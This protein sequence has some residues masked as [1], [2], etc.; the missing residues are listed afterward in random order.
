MVTKDIVMDKD[1]E[2]GEER[3]REVIS[4]SHA[5][6]EAYLLRDQEDKA[7][8][9]SPN[10]YQTIIELLSKST[11]PSIQQIQY[12]EGYEAALGVFRAASIALR[13]EMDVETLE[14]RLNS[15]KQA[16][17]DRQQKGEDVKPN[18]ELATL[19]K[20]VNEAVFFSNRYALYFAGQVGLAILKSTGTNTKKKFNFGTKLDATPDNE[21]LM[22]FLAD[23]ATTDLRRSIEADGKNM[24]EQLKVVLENIFT[25]WVNQFNW[26]THDKVAE[27]R[28]VK[29][30]N[31][32]YKTFSM[33]DGEFKRRFDSVE[34]D[35]KFMQ[36]KKEDVIGTQE[37]GE[38]LWRNLMKLACYDVDRNKNPMDPAF[39]IFTYGEPGGGKTFTAHAMVQ[40]FGDLC[41]KLGIPFKAYTHSST[42]YATSYQNETANALNTLAKEIKDF[43]GIVV[44]YVADADTILVSRKDP[45]LRIEQKQTLAVYNKMFDGTLIPKNG[46][47]MVI[48]DANELQGIDDATKSRLF[49]EIIEHK[50]F[51]KAEDF[52]ALAKSL[53]TKG[54]SGGIEMTEDDWAYVG[55]YLLGS[56][57][58]NREITSVCRRIRGEYDVP[59]EMLTKPFEDKLAYRT[60]KVKGLITKDNVI[61]QID[62]YINTRM[63]IE[64][65]AEESRKAN[66]VDRFYQA[67]IQRKDTS[68]SEAASVAR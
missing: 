31:L 65:K 19:E 20:E 4:T 3:V 59:E 40:S 66:D 32:K 2:N 10:L 67:V 36:V 60:D 58:S 8:T 50:R 45:D 16:Q 14:A 57:L 33:K 29:G 48:M 15:L 21:L 54:A 68:K 39:C 7:A 22:A 52:T 38:K 46:K 43:K 35:D 51:D 37:L 5:I 44:M 49:D 12:L 28:G 55:Q 24:D 1:V 9:L 63:E 34:I 64:R 53:L 6:I 61:F 18:G 17:F 23:S 41:K 47:F 30:L 62:D 11:R 42:D 25:T 13:Q 26:Y 27:A 56:K